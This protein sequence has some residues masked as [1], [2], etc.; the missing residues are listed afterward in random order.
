MREKYQ[1]SELTLSELGTRVNL[2]KSKLSEL[3]RGIGL[4]PR[5]ENVLGIAKVLGLP[6]WPLLHL[7]QQGAL[8][9]NKSLRWIELSGGEPVVL[10]PSAQ[11]VEHGVLQELVLPPNVPLRAIEAFQDLV[12]DDYCRYAQTFLDDQQSDKAIS[13]TFDVLWQ[14]WPDALASPDTRHYAWQV[15]RSCIMSLAPHVDGRPSLTSAAF[16]TTALAELTTETDRN[17]QIEETR[18]LFAAISRLPDRQLDVMVLSHLHGME[19]EHVSHL[20]GASLA[21]VRSEERYAIR[22]LNHVLSP[23]TETQGTTP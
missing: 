22:Y 17:A 9:A 16:H 7:W 10:T 15:L 2:S 3:L 11:S 18:S 21:T 1:A 20:L 8:D 6:Q 5:W 23:P 12:E 19:A 4:Y 13:E 14:S